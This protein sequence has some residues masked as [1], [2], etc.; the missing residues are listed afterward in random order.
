MK[1][2]H[3]IKETSYARLSQHLQVLIVLIA[4]VVVSLATIHVVAAILE[5]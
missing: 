1:S 2:T 3:S 5:M 4:T